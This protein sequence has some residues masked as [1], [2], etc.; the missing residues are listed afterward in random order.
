MKKHLVLQEKFIAPRRL[1]RTINRRNN[2]FICFD[3]IGKLKF[4]RRVYKNRLTNKPF[5]IEL[6]FTT[7][8]VE[9]TIKTAINAGARIVENPKTK[10]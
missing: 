8:N 3:N 4:K 7:D 6:G 10:P 1:W 9:E 2:T 5:G